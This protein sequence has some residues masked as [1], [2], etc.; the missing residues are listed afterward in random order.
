MVW[1]CGT[2]HWCNQDS[3]WLLSFWLMESVGLGSPKWHG[4]SW[5]RGI[6]ENGSSRLSTLMID[7]PGDLVWDLPC[8]QQASYLEGGPLKWMLHLYLHV[9]Q[10][11]DYDDMILR[12]YKSYRPWLFSDFCFCSKSFQVVH[13][14]V[15]LSIHNILVSQWGVSKKH[16]LFDISSY[17]WLFHSDLELCADFIVIR[18]FCWS[19]LPLEGRQKTFSLESLNS[20]C[21]QESAISF[22][23]AHTLVC[24]Q[25]LSFLLSLFFSKVYNLKY[26]L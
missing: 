5:Q 20:S 22:Y 21:M 17:V 15:H 7:I 26:S 12:I 10:K 8:V 11:S 9:N 14:Y 16:C 3:L 2:L 19:C 25:T 24:L 4:S 18:L 6:T 13:P 23:S 1:T